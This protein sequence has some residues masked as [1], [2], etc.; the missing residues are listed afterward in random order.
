MTAANPGSSTW[1][2]SP[3]GMSSARPAGNMS[4]AP[5]QAR[6]SMPAE[7]AVA[8]AGRGNSFP[9]RASR[10]RTLSGRRVFWSI[11]TG[12]Q[13]A[14]C[15]V[16]RRDTGAGGGERLGDERDQLAG[17]RQLGRLAQLMPLVAPQDDELVVLAIESFVV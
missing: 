13:L 5:R 2:A 14:Q 7:P 11:R 10:I 8:Y 12:S 15:R 3:V 1:I 16:A 17:Q 4:A 9:M 6:R